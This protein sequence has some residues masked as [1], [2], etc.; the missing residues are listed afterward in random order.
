MS[1]LIKQLLNSPFFPINSG[2]EEFSKTEK[3]EQFEGH[4][5]IS[6]LLQR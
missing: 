5:T 2:S 4:N 3:R 6:E 1:I